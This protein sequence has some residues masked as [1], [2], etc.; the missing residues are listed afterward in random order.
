MMISRLMLFPIFLIITLLQADWT[1]GTGHSL[2]SSNGHEIRLTGDLT[3]SGNF[4]HGDGLLSFAGTSAQSITGAIALGSLKI[5]NSTGLTLN[6]P[7]TVE[8]ILYLTDGNISTTEVN[9]LTLLQDAS[10]IPLGGSAS[11]YVSGPLVMTTN[12]TNEYIFP[13]GSSPYAPLAL[14]L[15]DTST[16]SY[17]ARYSYVAYSDLTF[18][19]SLTGI[20]AVEY[21]EIERTGGSTV[22]DSLKLFWDTRSD[23]EGNGITI[24][25]LCIARF[26]GSDWFKE[27]RDDWDGNDTSGGWAIVKPGSDISGLTAFT[28]GK[29]STLSTDGFLLPN[30]FQLLPAYPNPFNPQ[31]TI[32]YQLPRTTEVQLSVYDLQGRNVMDLV[33]GSQTAGSYRLVWQAG[34]LSSGVY[35][36]VMN[37][38][39]YT[40]NQKITL[41]K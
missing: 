22:I 3:V 14:R 30:E 36:L 24:N 34:S 9:L 33:Q 5:N 40:S 28:F 38:D 25:D 7:C 31:T 27:G 32:A 29:G 13:I 39:E 17:L 11:S 19:S 16:N 18:N 10:V 1:V 6:N 2:I 23:F 8:D 4:T 41:L 26:N 12:T 15:S 20:S 35:I 37:T 21:W